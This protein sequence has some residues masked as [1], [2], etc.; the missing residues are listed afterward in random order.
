[1]TTP[2]CPVHCILPPYLL[3][4]MAHSADPEVR[5]LAFDAI[6]V[7]AAARAMRAT[8]TAM[9]AMSAIP[10]PAGAEHRLV[11]D[12]GNRDWSS[13]P[14]EL[15][16]SEGEARVEDPSVNEAYDFSGA[17]YDFYKTVFGRNSLDDNGMA[18]LSSVHF[19]NRYDN[20]F[21]NG[22]QMV[23]GDGDGQVFTRFTKSLDVVGH[24]LSHGVVT[25]TCNLVYHGESGALNEHFA[26]VF[27]TLVKQWKRKQTVAT[28]TWLIGQEIMGPKTEAA[29]IRTFEDKKAYENDPVLG[30]DPQP[31][32]LKDEYTGLEDSGGVHI[33]SGIPNHAFYLVAQALGGHAWERA[34]RVW[35]DAVKALGPKS[36]F[37][38]MVRQTESS[39]ITL[40]GTGSRERAAVTS[41]WKAVGF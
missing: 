36:V 12:V 5:R 39:A 23:Y 37:L 2:R 31:K 6:G 22:E 15:V 14:G 21:W 9:P 35:Y 17:T 34:G 20:A 1:M 28:A 11:Y 40:F 4:H 3:D 13:L 33:N 24:E 10:S 27:G 8:M 19:G 38:D 41:A 26:D 16:R 29:A 25:H 18:L 32:R 7:S 30:T